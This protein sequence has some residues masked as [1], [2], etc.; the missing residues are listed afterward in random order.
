MAAK[1]PFFFFFVYIFYCLNT[2]V[3]TKLEEKLVAN[4]KGLTMSTTCVS[5][6][7]IIVFVP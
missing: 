3:T 1:K 5:V 6:G 4:R 2:V 7:M